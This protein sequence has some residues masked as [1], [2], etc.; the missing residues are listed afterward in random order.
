MIFGPGVCMCKI[1]KFWKF[2]FCILNSLSNSP[3]K[4]QQKLETVNI[5]AWSHVQT[6]RSL[7]IK[8][9]EGIFVLFGGVFY[10]YFLEEVILTLW[11]WWHFWKMSSK[12]TKHFVNW[13]KFDSWTHIQR[14]L[15]PKWIPRTLWKFVFCK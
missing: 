2:Q 5:W 7:Q 8:F 6:P 12:I 11:K 14:L 3:Y 10:I 15:I 13:C 1:W 9:K 4:F